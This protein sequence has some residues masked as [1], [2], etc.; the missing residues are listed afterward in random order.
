[1]TLDAADFQSRKSPPI[2]L[3]RPLLMRGEMPKPDFTEN[4][5]LNFGPFNLTH[6]KR[7]IP[8]DVPS[9]WY[10]KGGVQVP[11]NIITGSNILRHEPGSTCLNRRYS[12]TDHQHRSR[13]GIRGEKSSEYLLPDL[14]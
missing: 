14:E 5:T 11:I 4:M 2:L 7:T 12:G 13:V 10:T 6:D 8:K 9:K 1:M 3:L